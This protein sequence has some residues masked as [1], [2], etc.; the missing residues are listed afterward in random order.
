MDGGVK[1]IFKTLIKVPVYIYIAFFAFN[2][3][4]FCFVYFKMLGLSYMVQ[5]IAVENN[6]IPGTGKS[7]DQRGSLGSYIASIDEDIGMVSNI[8]IVTKDDKGTI[9]AGIQSNPASTN[10]YSCTN[11]NGK[12][13]AFVKSE[14]KHQ[15][16]AQVDIGVQCVYNWVW[17]LDYRNADDISY[18]GA[19]VGGS[20]L[21]G[22]TAQKETRLNVKSGDDLI[23]NQV[24]SQNTITIMYRV[25]GLKYYPDIE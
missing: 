13:S 24:L 15:Y 7:S 17:P 9:Q 14:S 4:A 16:G 21:G 2:I 10:G 20:T 23:D 8:R 11:V 6:Y 12:N 1:F 18:E 19:E 25:P 3:F 22:Y 5:Q